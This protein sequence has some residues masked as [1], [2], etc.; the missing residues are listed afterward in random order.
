MD[1]GEDARLWEQLFFDHQ[2]KL[3]CINAP[4]DFSRFESPPK[5]LFMA[6]ACREDKDKLKKLIAE[7]ESYRNMDTET[8]EMME[9]MAGMKSS[10]LM[11]PTRILSADTALK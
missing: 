9:V 7:N 4:E 10:I 8:A 1:F 3:I 5:E 11:S 6:I 2:M